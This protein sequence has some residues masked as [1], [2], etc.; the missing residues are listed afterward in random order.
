MSNTFL[1]ALPLLL[2]LVAA[3]QWLLAR[4]KNRLTV[5]DD[6]RLTDATFQRWRVTII[7]AALM[8]AFLFGAQSLP[9]QWQWWLMVAFTFAVLLT[10]VVSTTMQWRSLAR[11]GVAQS[12]LHTQLW[13]FVVMDI[14]F[15][16]FFTLMLYEFPPVFSH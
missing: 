12:Y 14:V 9:R 13:V 3:T 15:I 10:T 11:S 5:E 6:A 16:A 2:I 1:V 7:L 4:A 8:F